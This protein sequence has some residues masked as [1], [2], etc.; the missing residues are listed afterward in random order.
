[1]YRRKSFRQSLTRAN[2]TQ[3][4]PPLPR[5]DPPERQKSI[6]LPYLGKRSDRIAKYLKQFGYRVG[7]YTLTSVRNLSQLKDPVSALDR[8]VVY[9]L[10]CGSCPSEYI[11]QT[12]G[13][14][15]DRLTEHKGDFTK[16]QKGTPLTSLDNPSAMAVHC[17]QENYHFTLV[18]SKF[19]TQ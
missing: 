11:G 3:L 1:M 12:G 13:R 2:S 6:R 16:L 5:G 15:R 17:H 4:Q 18:K 7:F 8:S 14:L 10:S 19:C 9:R